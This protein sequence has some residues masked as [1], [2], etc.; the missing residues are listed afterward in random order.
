MNDPL[1]GSPLTPLPLAKGVLRLHCPWQRRC[2]YR[3]GYQPYAK[4]L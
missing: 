4:V 1:C 2:R 3:R